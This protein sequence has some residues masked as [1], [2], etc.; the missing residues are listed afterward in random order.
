MSNWITISTKDLYNS[1]AAPYVDRADT[2]LLGQGQIKRSDQIIADVTAEVRRKV[3]KVNSLDVDVTKIPA[4]LKTLAVDL[5]IARLKKAIG[6][7]LSEGEMA[8]LAAH[9][10][11]LDRIADGKDN[12]DLPDNPIPTSVTMQG[13][14][15]VAHHA[16]PRQATARKLG[17]LL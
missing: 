9:T 10:K 2:Q 11:T 6:I 16:N 14:S 17:G 13:G 15:Q 1:A 3:S 12:V 8:D 4:G 5:I 7:V